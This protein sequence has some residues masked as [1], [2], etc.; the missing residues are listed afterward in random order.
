MSPDARKVIEFLSKFA[1]CD[2][3]DALVKKGHKDGGYFPNLTRYS[4]NASNISMIGKAY[5]VLFASK[6][7]PRPAIEGGYIDKLP[8]D[9]VLIIATTT[10]LQKL[11]A[12][13]TKLN[14]ALYGG[15]MSTRAQYLKS[16]GTVVFGRI[17]DLDEHRDLNRDVFSYGIGSAAHAPVVK[18][19]GI[20]VPVEIIIDEYSESRKEVINPGDYIMGDNNGVVRV[21]DN[22]ELGN[23]LEYI[24]K[25]VEA[26]NLVKQ[27]ILKGERCN[28]SQKK[29]REGL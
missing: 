1:T 28:A 2:L 8:E 12:P 26:D 19:I 23:L 25:R 18:M 17:R 21:E 11:D 10:N 13:Y 24:P 16:R 22:E 20:N 4:S 9:S 27:D 3:S 6:D 14:N 15:L 7:D 29:R 5:T